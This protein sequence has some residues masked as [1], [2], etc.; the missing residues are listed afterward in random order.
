MRQEA[1]V[2]LLSQPNGI[3]L[4]RLSPR[5]RSC[6]QARMVGISVAALLQLRHQQ[7]APGVRYERVTTYLLAFEYGKFG[8][9]TRHTTSPLSQCNLITTQPRSFARTSCRCRR[10]SERG[11]YIHPLCQ[12]VRF[13]RYPTVAGTVLVKLVA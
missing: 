2:I 9:G 6:R 4:L 13:S 3:R 11:Q 1:W 10:T 5:Q 8:L 7:V 12:P